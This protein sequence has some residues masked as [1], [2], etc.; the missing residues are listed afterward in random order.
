MR[1][2]SK[3]KST[4]TTKTPKASSPAAQRRMQATRQ[5]DTACEINL[6][7][8]LRELGLR[9]R[10]DWKLP[11]TRRRADVAFPS[12]KVAVMVDGCFWHACPLHGSWPKKNARWWRE[13]ILAN[14]KRDRDTD[15]C[16]A[17]Q[18]WRVLRLW[19]H[20]HSSK[21][22]RKIHATLCGRRRSLASKT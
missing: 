6:R 20:E 13:K 15:S 3:S 11:D 14:R 5:R 4:K 1:S 22:A 12:V 2:M 19:E 8:A 10:V 9:Y 17:A 18:G 16:L 21:A 7:S